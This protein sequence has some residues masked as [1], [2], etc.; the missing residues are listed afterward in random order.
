MRLVIQTELYL[1]SL[2]FF[3]CFF[4]S[5]NFFFLIFLLFLTL[6]VAWL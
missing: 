2:I 4:L 1:K 3:F 6:G 5:K